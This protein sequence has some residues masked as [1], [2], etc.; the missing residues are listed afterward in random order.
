VASR[1]DLHRPLGGVGHGLH[2]GRVGRHA[3]VD[4]EDV[5][6]EV[7]VGLSGLDQVGAGLGHALQHR[8][9]DVAG[10]GAP[11]QAEQAAPGAVV[12]LRRAQTQEGGHVHH[13]VGRVTGGGDRKSVGHVVDQAQVVA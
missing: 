1:G 6:G 8:P 10:L 5:D 4:P 13:A 2:E 11:G 3:A 9:H 12:P 7:T